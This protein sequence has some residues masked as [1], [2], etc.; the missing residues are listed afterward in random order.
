[1]DIIELL[2]QLHNDPG[3]VLEP[4]QAAILQATISNE[5]ELAFDAGQSAQLNLLQR[6]LDQGSEIGGWKIGMTSGANR[7][8]MGDG[9]RPFGYV[10]K[11]RIYQSGARLELSDL[12][13][14]Q[15]ENELAFIMG[16]HLGAGATADAAFAAV[17]GVLPAFEINQKRLPGS[18][19]SGLRVADDLSNYGIVVGTPVSPIRDLSQ[20]TVTLSHTNGKVIEAVASAGHIDDHYESLAI[21]ARRLDQF[22]QA[23]KPGHVVIT[24]AYGKTPFAAGSFTGHFDQGIGTVE[25]TLA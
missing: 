7:N 12:H 10:L 13:N 4:A 15:V 21:L 6:W 18:A 2:W 8:A 16:E 24:G 17:A 9:I 22:G 11:E 14:G 1:M 5:P 25:V 23:L 20:L 19:S 3:M